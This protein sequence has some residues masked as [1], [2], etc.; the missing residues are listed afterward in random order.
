MALTKDQ[1]IIAQIIARCW[2][3]PVYQAAVRANPTDEFRKA[4]VDMQPGDVIN[5]YD[6]DLAN[7]HFVIPS[8]PL[9]GYAAEDAVPLF[10]LQSRSVAPRKVKKAPTR[11]PVA[12]KGA[13]K[14]GSAK[15]GGAKKGGA[16]KPSAR[17][18]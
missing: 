6:A 5:V 18:R 8:K 16:N 2:T 7:R 12:K 15:K 1:K 17:A 4:G 11:K 3:D 14:K 9:S 13:A 10:T